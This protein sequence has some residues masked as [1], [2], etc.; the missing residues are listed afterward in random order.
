MPLLF[1]TVA[2]MAGIAA[3]CLMPDY[4]VHAAVLTAV[5]CIA[6]FMARMC[7]VSSSF[8]FAAIGVAVAAVG[9]PQPIAFEAD[10]E[11][12]LHTGVVTAVTRSD[13]NQRLLVRTDTPDG[14][15]NVAVSY[16]AM[17]PLV[18]AGDGIE[19][20]APVRPL[21]EHYLAP[22]EFFPRGYYLRNAVSATAH[23]GAGDLQIVS[24]A[25]GW[26]HTLDHWRSQLSHFIFYRCGLLPNAADML[27]AVLTGNDDMLSPVVRE[28]FARSGTAH[29]LALSGMH[30]AVIAFMVSLL[31][32]PLSLAGHRHAGRLC[33][34][35]AVWFYVALVGFPPS[36]TRT[37]VMASM[38]IG[39]QLLFRGSSS[40]NNLC[41]AAIV[42]LVVTPRS[43]FS[44]AFQLSFSAVASILMFMPYMR[45]PKRYP[46]VVRLLWQWCAV[47]ICAMAGTCV[48]SAY[49][50][51][52]MPLLFLAANLPLSLLL[53]PFMIIGVLMVVLSWAGL[54]VAWA[55]WVENGIYEAMAT[56]CGWIAGVDGGAIRAVYPGWPLV[57]AGYVALCMLWVSLKRK[58]L[59][60]VLAGIM[61]LGA[62]W[63]VNWICADN[64]YEPHVSALYDFY[65]TT[66]LAGDGHRAVVLTDAPVRHH[67]GLRERLNFRLGDYMARRGIDSLDIV[68]TPFRS[69]WIEADSAVWRIGDVRMV[70]LNR[71]LTP[72]DAAGR[73]DMHNADFMIVTTGFRG[74]IEQLVAAL[75][76]GCVVLSRRLGAERRQ[77]LEEALRA[78]G[79]V[80][81]VGLEGDLSNASP[82]RK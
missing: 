4:T 17:L 72:E 51:H 26:R 70:L 50:F 24:P 13:Y 2:F 8:L 27:D 59:A 54:P 65:G 7:R 38:L 78:A 41:L 77:R 11:P 33:V 44:P 40:M 48:L 6:F 10:N 61:V 23:V 46:W 18:E 25:T 56:V 39:G 36:V 47:S 80:Y 9:N 45:L 75:R 66:V 62:V 30:V 43:L 5:A 58:K 20:R 57:A 69:A 73:P 3:G 42:I 79:T 12:H 60:P 22:D 14:Y 53:P 71:P 31:F 52:Q 74:D 81:S 37:A 28:R 1:P 63:G 55:A 64:R 34:L 35:L 49:Y 32:W 16:H 76:P 29:V 68:S 21:A 82:R 19:F 15:A 67:A